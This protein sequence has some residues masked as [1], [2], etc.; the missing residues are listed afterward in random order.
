MFF[1]KDNPLPR[2]FVCS[3]IMYFERVHKSKRIGMYYIYKV[4][5]HI[6]QTRPEVVHKDVSQSF[7]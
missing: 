4:R 3:I 2:R 5:V 7:D 6:I 1:R